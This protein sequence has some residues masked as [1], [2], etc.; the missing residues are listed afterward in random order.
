[1]QKISRI[2]VS[3]F[4]FATGWYDGLMFDLRDPETHQPTDT[5]FNLEN[6]GGKTSLLSYVFSCFE[7]EQQRWLQHLQKKSHRFAEYFMRDAR[8]SFIAIEWEMPGRTPGAEPYLLVVGQAVAIAQGADRAVDADRWFFSFESVPGL[9]LSDIP[10][11]GIHP[12]PVKSMPEFQQ[13][14]NRAGKIAGD[15]FHTRSQGDWVSHLSKGRLIDVDLLKMQVDFNSREGGVEQGFLDFNTEY[16]LLRRFLQLTI[17]AEMAAGV[18]ESIIQT[19]D[20]LRLRPRYQSRVQYL[21][22]LQTALIP[23]GVRAGEYEAAQAEHEAVKSLAAGLSATLTA[24]RAALIE[25]KRD[26]ERHA[27]VQEGLLTQATAASIAADNDRTTI[28]GL[29]FNRATA[30]ARAAATQADEAL[31]FA[32]KLAHIIDATLA[33]VR[34]EAEEHNVN[35]LE[36]LISAEREGLKPAKD[37]A[38]TQ[39]ALF[40]AGLAIAERTAEQEAV[41]ARD[42]KATAERRVGECDRRLQDIGRELQT[43]VAEQARLDQFLQIAKDRRARLERDG[44]MEKDDPTAADA[45]ARLEESLATHTSVM[46]AELE[47][48]QAQARRSA[49]C[50]EQKDAEEKE[51][52]RLENQFEAKRGFIAAGEALREKLSQTPILMQAAGAEVADPDSPEL[53][54]ALDRLAADTL[55]SI[56]DLN[57]ELAKVNVDRGAITETG[58]AG[59]SRDVDLVVVALLKENIRSARPA[60]TYLADTQPDASAARGL[61][62]S[63]PSRYLGVTVAAAE[64]KEA[65]RIAANLK[66]ELTAPVTVAVNSLDPAAA[67]LDRVVLPAVNDAAYNRAAAQQVL[68]T[69]ESRAQAKAADLKSYHGR[70]D[71]A[72]AAGQELARYVDQYGLAVLRQAAA[73]AEQLQGQVNAAVTKIK[74]LKENGAEAKRRSEE[75]LRASRKAEQ[76]MVAVKNHLRDVRDYQK[77]FEEPMAGKRAA[78]ADLQQRRLQAET[79][80]LSTQEDRGA[81]LVEAQTAAISCSS[82]TDRRRQL[83]IERTT[84]KYKDAAFPAAKQLSQKPQALE[85][86]RSDYKLAADNFEIE[87]RQRLGTMGERLNRARLDLQGAKQAFQKDFSNVPCEEI[88]KLRGRDLEAMAQQQRTKIPELDT[89]ARAA[90]KKLASAETAETLYWGTKKARRAPTPAMI[91]LSDSALAE[92]RQRL[93][94]EVVRQEAAMEQARKQKGVALEVARNA[95][96]EASRLRT[97]Q[98]SLS[99]AIPSDETQA[100]ISDPGPDIE[101][102]VTR[103]I[104]DFQQRSKVLSDARKRADE[105]FRRLLLV[106]GNK[107]LV[108]VEPEVSRDIQESDFELACGDRRRIVDLVADRIRAAQDLLD[109]MTPDFENCAGELYNLAMEGLNLL[110]RALEKKMPEAAPYIG[111]KAIMRMP[112]MPKLN[113]DGRR[114]G[115]RG[116]LSELIA[117]P[118]FPANGADIVA[119]CLIR[120]SGRKQ[121]GLEVIRMEQNTQYQYQP[122]GELKGSRGQASVI[123]VLLYMLMSQLRG[124][125]RARATRY[126][127]GPLILDNPFANVQT[128]ALIDAQRLLANALGVQLIFFT[129]SADA[130]VIAGFR[131]VIRLRK[132]GVNSKTHRSHIQMAAAAF[133]DLTGVAA[134]ATIDG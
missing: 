79:R 80:Q 1:M 107:E 133:D 64:W 109:A 77:A 8:P 49:E 91:E 106:A 121:L 33:Q 95:E 32:K 46:E 81:A 119:D 17:D 73:E 47:S 13:W 57:V 116:Y 20:K 130:N 104:A 25:R 70:R 101:A 69:L 60:N 114:D 92:E 21:T 48:G 129:A 31:G 108:E 58:V 2:L 96:A 5:V 127:G 125:T 14:M 53:K 89:T 117:A 35:S 78:Q 54:F 61:V 37:H 6:S 15:F 131:Q 19:A 110:T 90:G 36:A 30:A 134:G 7:P 86:L 75:H 68:T 93:T 45:I 83:G 12:E 56:A 124:D 100:S 76:E 26:H 10:A 44:L 105:E 122:A 16:D 102:A 18:R 62:V 120:W 39:G 41:T 11:E 51:L 50:F 43:M 99:A 3:R 112:A 24:R 65:C 123:A 97:L 66:I 38:E 59:R 40:D 87:E 88:E 28:E 42:T 113:A 63:D 111:G 9:E 55:R 74:T 126:G 67:A 34:V 72:L 94:V 128:R 27:E 85:T 103:A 71:Q 22:Q 23:F 29:Q 98:N 84:I 118:K 52:P 4:G 132:S 115:I 82:A